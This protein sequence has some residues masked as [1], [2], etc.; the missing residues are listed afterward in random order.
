MKIRLNCVSHDTE[1]LAKGV[2]AELERRKLA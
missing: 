1:Q 2:I